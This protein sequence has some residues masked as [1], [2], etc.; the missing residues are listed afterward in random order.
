MIKAID[1]YSV[2]VSRQSSIESSHLSS[3]SQVILSPKDTH[4]GIQQVCLA[5]HQLHILSVYQE[6]TQ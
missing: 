3:R 4:P 1:I 2:P 6:D 5:N